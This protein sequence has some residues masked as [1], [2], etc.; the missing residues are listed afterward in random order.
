MDAWTLKHLDT[1]TL[2]HLDT[3]TRERLDNWTRARTPEITQKS[4]KINVIENGPEH[5]RRL[6]KALRVTRDGI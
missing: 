5:L 6:V 1:W 4:S 3:W 2:G